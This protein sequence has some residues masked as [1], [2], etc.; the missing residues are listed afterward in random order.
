[1]ATAAGQP[2]GEPLLQDEASTAELQA[3]LLSAQDLEDF[4]QEVAVLAAARVAPG[5][6][7]GITLRPSG[8]PTTVASSDA[9]AAQVDEIQYGIE[10]GP[11]LSAMRNG[12]V[13]H[14][15]DTAAE[16]RWGTFETE[17]ADRGV[18]SSL[19]MP[20]TADGLHVGAL[21]LYA[22]D[23][24]TFGEAEYRRAEAFAATATGALTLA[25]RHAEQADL[26]EHLRSALA[27]RAVIDQ[28]LG[29]IMA[30]Q[31]CASEEAFGILR[32]ASQHRNV[33]LR[34]V[35]TDIVTSV[36]GQPPQSPPFQDRPGGNSQ[37]PSAR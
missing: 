3:L 18:G 23:A 5:L 16:P 13:V 11:C 10:N 1:M 27:S 17:A 32:A 14:V 25:I 36:S 33:K 22:P 37:D 15:E 31:R 21:N 30:Q 28:A 2:A 12:K 29:I 34:Q 7:C 4:L 9:F 20:L 24:G 35:A 6:S 8:R 26:T 19:S